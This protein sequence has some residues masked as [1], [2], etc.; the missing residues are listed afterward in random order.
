MIKNNRIQLI[1][2]ACLRAF[3]RETMPQQRSL[4]YMVDTLPFTQEEKQL[5]R[6][7]L[8]RLGAWEQYRVELMVREVWNALFEVH[9]LMTRKLVELDARFEKKLLPVNF[10][11][12]LD[13][14]AADAMVLSADNFQS[15]FTR[16]LMF[17]LRRRWGLP[18]PAG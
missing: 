16:L 3:R 8:A 4:P 2:V 14:R 18:Q 10:E 12:Y 15:Y 13:E 5:L 17:H 7:K 9:R 11:H 6:Q 1:S